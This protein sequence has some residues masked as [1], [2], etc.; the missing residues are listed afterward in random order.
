MRSP[1][2]AA[3][4]FMLAS[5]AFAQGD[6]GTITGVVSDPAGAVVAGAQV[7][8][9]N[10]ETGAIYPATT[11]LA[12]VY[13]LSQ[14]PVGTY[15]VS[16]TVPG[17]K[18][19]VRQ[20]LRVEVA[21][22]LG[23]DISLEVGAA[24]ESV[25]V[26]GEASMLKTE[27]A[28]VSHNVTVQTLNDLPMLGTGSS[29]AGSSGIRNPNNVTLL[30]PGT[31]YQ[32]NSNVKINGAPTN[33]EAFVVEGMDSSNQLIDFAP[34][35]MQPSVDAIQEVSIQT[36]NYA[37]EYG[38]A[39]GGYFNVTMKS[40]TNQY[41]GSLYDYAV[42][43]VLN[44]GTPFTSDP[45]HTGNLIRPRQRRHDYGW[46]VGG[47]ASI[48][49]LYNGHDRTFFFFNFE[50]FRETQNINNIVQTVPIDAYRNGD[51]SQATAAVNNR[52]LTDPFGTLTLVQ[53]T[54]YDPRTSHPMN[55]RMVTDPFPLNKIDPDRFDP[56][57]VAV[58]KLIPMPTRPGLINNYLPSYPSVRHT[59]IPAVKIDELLGSKAKLSFYWSFTHTDSQYSP[60]YG[61]SDGLP[62]PITEARGTFIHT[63]TY[64]LNYDH[65][66][67]PTLLLHLSAGY[68]DNN[69][70]DAA[71]VLD[72]NAQQ[73][74]GL[75]GATVNRN[76]PNFT[77]FCP[78]VMG[79]GPG[80]IQCTTSTAGGMKNMGP[81]NS[82]Q[83]NQWLQ[84]P[85]GN[86]SLI[87][88]KGSHTYKFGGGFQSIGIPVIQYANTNGNYA[89]ATRE[90]APPYL[91]D[92]TLSGGSVGF[93]YA[94]F[95]LGLVDQVQIAPPSETRLGKT[96]YGIFVQD[97]WRMRRKLTLDYGARW[98]YSPYPR[99]QYGRTAVFSPTTLNPNAGN[100]PGGWVFE[101]NGPGHCNCDFAKNYPYA[102]GPRLGIAYQ[103]TSKTVF[104]AG[105]GLL[106]GGTLSTGLAS[107][108]T[109]SI[110][111]PGSG[112][113]AMILKNGI[114]ITPTWPV[115]SPGLF[116]AIPGAVTLTLPTNVGMLDP[117]AG[118][119][120]RQNQWSIGIQRE[121]AR[122]LVVEA[123]YVAN[124]GVWWR[125]ITAQGAPAGTL[126]FD[127]INALTPERIKAAG[128]DINSPDDVRLL[129]SP[130]SSASAV[131]RG[132]RPPF[133]GY[134]LGQTLAQSLRPFPQFG[135]IPVIGSPVGNTWYDSLQTKATKRYSHGL[136]FTTVFTWQKSLQEGI[137]PANNIYNDV[138]VRPVAKWLSTF[139]QPLVLT[140]TGSYQ[141]P[142][143]GGNKWL[144]SIVRDWQIGTLLT[145][146]SGRPIPAPTA[147]TPL[148]NELFQQTFANRVPGEPLYTVSDINCH[149]YDPSK[150]FVLNRKAW[151]NPPDGQFGATAGFFS[152]YRYQR[153]PQE[154]LNFGRTFRIKERYSLNLR[155]E[156]SNIFNRTYYN[157]PSAN[158]PQNAQ[159]V[160]PP[161]GLNASGFGYINT[162]ITGTQFGQP[163][164]GTIVARFQF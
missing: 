117:N 40:G 132:F 65:T 73:Q 107:A 112:A 133:S 63:T 137:E 5:A 85:G 160:N 46:T 80:V 138:F 55:G 125:S 67:S 16:V 98:D 38:G 42:N 134:P 143:W 91:A 89:F 28:D 66:L 120:P 23:I 94:S 124:R 25:T 21:Q 123:S 103:I 54:I 48:P 108:A 130:L 47:P 151:T 87:W 140:I 100:L 122:D 135:N 43:E 74:L 35:Q 83:V 82:A 72:Y 109:S 79:T 152:D 9:K 32:A 95:L 49:K 150:T 33:S 44:A 57:A 75:K 121:L 148:N 155:V 7:E 39:G 110:T 19:F 149:C 69:F 78:S 127:N 30:V 17:F 68:Q 56:V 60:T 159:T 4:L 70:L 1:L 104:R 153:H 161:T 24:S 10:A 147:T 12:G 11:T 15:E 71:P 113:P 128:L 118:R 105:W 37:A 106:Y 41:H 119:P 88:V 145:Y 2:I 29:Q 58:Q 129:T 26:T 59:T 96:G 64:R 34:A 99:E 154:S 142:K 157:D 158:G 45:D 126:T 31:F 61:N 50:Q 81:A 102:I 163:R 77:G 62:T 18:K 162:S 164:Q 146:A 90:T 116:P 93:G 27:S 131:A 101:G 115:F 8:G 111:S 6:R 139:D 13:T 136:T 86:A 20:G 22:T 114:P 36:S 144:S 52:V 76:F 14:L 92:T 51:F 156:F 141:L 3:C 84:K 97:S 53:N